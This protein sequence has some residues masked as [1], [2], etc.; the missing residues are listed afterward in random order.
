MVCPKDTA[1]FLFN[2][3]LKVVLNYRETYFLVRQKRTKAAIAKND[4]ARII[5]NA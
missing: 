1:I 2:S 3:G 5:Q 4:M